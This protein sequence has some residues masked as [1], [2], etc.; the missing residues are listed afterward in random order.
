[1]GSTSFNS[2]QYRTLSGV[3][4]QWTRALST[5]SQGSAFVQYTLLRF[6]S[7]QL[8]DANR[9]ILGLAYAEAVTPALTAFATVLG[10]QE[11]TTNAGAQFN[12]QNIIGLRL[13]TE[14]ALGADAKLFANLN[15]EQRS[16]QGQDFFF[17][18]DR[19]DTQIDF[20]L[21]AQ[22]TVSRMPWGS[23]RITP[24]I[25][26]TRNRSNI[27]LYTFDRTAAGVTARLDF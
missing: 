26:Y 2:Q 15:A 18:V 6:P 5:R 14:Y 8:R 12:D 10:G 9:T 19:K 3:S 27:S 11:R 23:V 1:M 25:S 24:Q 4:G 21:G 7:A 22:F 20:S 17:G 16:H 13:G